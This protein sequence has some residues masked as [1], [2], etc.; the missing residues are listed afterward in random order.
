MCVISKRTNEE[1]E[2]GEIEK[3]ARQAGI[4]LQ[5]AEILAALG[6][7]GAC[8]L[9]ERMRILRLDPVQF[10]AEEPATF[11]EL[12]KNCSACEARARCIVDLRNDA[13]NPTGTNW[14]DYCPNVATLR[15]CSS[16]AKLGT[17]KSEK[18]SAIEL[19]ETRSSF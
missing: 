18:S 9:L 12:Q 17:P 19:A 16:L 7:H 4:S 14:Y 3:S 10:S 8:L 1:E 11:R 2:P 6:I 13:I 15:M 5:D